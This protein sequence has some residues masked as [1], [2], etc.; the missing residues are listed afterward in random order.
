[1]TLGLI[2]LLL[3]GIAIAGR[4]EDADR[5]AF[6]V[7]VV[8]SL[9]V[10]P[11]LW[12]HYFVLLFVPIALYRPRLSAVWFVPLLLWLTPVTQPQGNLWRICLA[13]GIAAL[14][15]AVTIGERRLSSLDGIGAL[16]PTRPRNSNPA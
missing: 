3:V 8:G 11:L 16:G 5:R 6:S 7:A 10:T 14:V 12:L 13:L 4:G 1:V 2:A 15:T 9:L